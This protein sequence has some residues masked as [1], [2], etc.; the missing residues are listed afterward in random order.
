MGVEDFD[1]RYQPV[2]AYGVNG[3]TTPFYGDIEVGHS[4]TRVVNNDSRSYRDVVFSIL[5]VIN[6]LAFAALVTFSYSDRSPVQHPTFQVSCSD[7]DKD[8]CMMTDQQM[9][10]LS[11]ISAVSVGIAALISC[12]S[13][14]LSFKFPRQSGII[15]LSIVIVYCVASTILF[16]MSGNYYGG[17]VMLIVALVELWTLYN[18]F[19]YID[20]AEHLIK[21]V[22]QIASEHNGT[23]VAA[24]AVTILMMLWVFVWYVCCIVLLRNWE[25]GAAWGILAYALFTLYWI[26]EVI[27]NVTHVTIAGSAASWY[28]E[29]ASYRPENPTLGAFYRSV[30]FS[31]GSICLGSMIVAILTTLRRMLDILR[32]QKGS[33]NWILVILS[34]V[35]SLIILCIE[36]LLRIFNKYV[37]TVIA[38]Y[39]DTYLTAAR[40]TLR[41]FGEHGY[42]MVMQNNIVVNLIFAT[43]LVA[44]FSCGYAAYFLAHMWIPDFV[45]LAILVGIVVG[46]FVVDGAY[47]VLDSGTCALLVCYFEENA[48]LRDRRP[49]LYALLAE[50]ERSMHSGN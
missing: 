28:F 45:S 16:F 31:F 25:G 5:F 8:S 15:A 46:V 22:R 42:E 43:Q 38:I 50:A 10:S 35:A 13:L 2:D 9:Q 39:G 17:V 24:I 3:D 41:I 44:G 27:K 32:N 20:F 34:F 19:R 47:T 1:K 49:E 48:V 7:N 21:T 26:A 18:Y 33:K 36:A 14:L 4:T 37:F 23:W 30:T 11:F 29:S 40:K 12:L 6:I